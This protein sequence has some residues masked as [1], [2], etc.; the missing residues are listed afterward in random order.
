MKFN[1]GKC[2]AM[3]LVAKEVDRRRIHPRID[4]MARRSVLQIPQNTGNR[5]TRTLYQ[6]GPYTNSDPRPTR[7]LPTRTLCRT[8]S[9]PIP[10]RT[11]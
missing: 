11:P 1:I 4:S 10:T 8:N 9:D 7:T 2:F 6:L 3:R 5:T